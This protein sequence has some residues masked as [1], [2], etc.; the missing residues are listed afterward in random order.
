[1]MQIVIQT[2]QG[3]FIV[4]TEKQAELIMWLE[5]NAI[6]AG[7]QNVRENADPQNYSGRQLINE[8]LGR[9]F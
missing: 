5:S 6:K 9:G 8:D 2:I 7:S 4:P 3:T 1:M